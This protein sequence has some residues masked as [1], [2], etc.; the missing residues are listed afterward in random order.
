MRRIQFTDRGNR[1]VTDADA[2]RERVLEAWRNCP[3]N[4][5]ARPTVTFPS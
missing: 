2:L 5:L 1:T 3:T 4:S